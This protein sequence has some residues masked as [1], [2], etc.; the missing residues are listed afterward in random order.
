[1]V[2]RR[3]GCQMCGKAVLLDKVAFARVVVDKVETTRRR[4]C[5]ECATEI[6]GRVRVVTIVGTHVLVWT[7][8]GGLGIARS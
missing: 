7:M 6:L 3:V 8:G 5:P 4:V 2:A 1:M